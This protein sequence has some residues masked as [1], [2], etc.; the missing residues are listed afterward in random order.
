MQQPWHSAR[1]VGGQSTAE[2]W[3]NTAVMLSCAHQHLYSTKS[4]TRLVLAGLMDDAEITDHE[5]G[6][7]NPER[8]QRD[9]RT[10]QNLMPESS[11]ETLLPRQHIR[12]LHPTSA[13]PFQSSPSPS[14]T[15][16][17]SK[18]VPEQRATPLA[19]LMVCLP[20]LKHQKDFQQPSNLLAHVLTSSCCSLHVPRGL[21]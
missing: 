15:T 10:P 2:G 18:N 8:A 6:L 12:S 5:L 9:L 17:F 7:L 11:A 14:L 16:P 4:F 1:R 13:N 21:H 19:A 3:S 20:G